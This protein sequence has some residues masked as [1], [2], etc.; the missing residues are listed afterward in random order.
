MELVVIISSLFANLITKWF[1]PKD[2]VLSEEQKNVRKFA[3]RIF[4]AGAGIVLFIVTANVLNEP[5]DTATLQGMIETLG[6]LALT[7]LSSQGAYLV[8]KK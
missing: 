5:I 8:N 1:K 3:I 2:E 6:G 7:Y 4:N